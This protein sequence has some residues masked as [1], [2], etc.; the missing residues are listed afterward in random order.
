GGT[1]SFVSE[2][3]LLSP[4]GLKQKI[5]KDRITMMWLTSSLCNIFADEDVEIFKPLRK[6]FTGGEA[7]SPSHIK[8]IADACPELELYN[9]YGP[10]ENTTFTTV[11]KI[12]DNELDGSPIPIGRPISNTRVYIVN[13][14]L[15]VVAPGEWGEICAAGDGLALK[16]I[17]RDD[18][19]CESFVQLPAPV[20]ERVYR[21]G[22]KGR[23]RND[24][25]VEFGGRIDGQVKIRGYRIEMSEIEN[26][27]NLYPGIM[28]SAVLSIDRDKEIHLV[29][30]IKSEDR[31]PDKLL[32]YL[33]KHLPEYMIPEQFEYI[34]MIPFTSNGKMDRK[35]L[36]SIIQNK[37][38]D[39][40]NTANCNSLETK[41]LNIFSDILGEAIDSVDSDFFQHGG[42]SLKALKL[43]NRIRKEICKD[44]DLRIVM[45][46]PTPSKLAKKIM[47]ESATFIAPE[48]KEL[49]TEES[50]FIP[51][52][53]VQERMWFLQEMQ[54]ESTVYTIPFAARIKSEI[55]LQDI[56]KV[57]SLLES[58]HEALRLRMSEKMENTS[59][60]QKLV[61]PGS[62]IVAYHDFS[63]MP[64]AE[65]A[66]R[67]AIYKERE[68]P[69]KFGYDEPLIRLALFRISNNE[70]V[71]FINIHHI[72]F[73][74]VSAS[75]ILREIQLAFQAVKEKRVPA[76][77]ELPLQYTDYLKDIAGR[78]QT[79]EEMKQRWVK[80]MSPLPESLQLPYDMRRPSKQTF[81]G[82]CFNFSLSPEL[83]DGIVN[84]SNEM[85]ITVFTVLLSVVKVF[86]YRHT[87][88]KD[89]VIGV[90]V[91]GRTEPDLEEMV[92]L[93][94]NTLPVR[95]SIEPDMSFY[96][97][98]KGVSDRLLDALSDQ[99]LQL[100]DLINSLK[101]PRNEARNPLFDVLVAMED[102][103]WHIDR[104]AQYL[105][106][107]KYS[108]PGFH[109]RMDLCFYFH[110]DET[111]IN[112]CIEYSTDL[113]YHETIEKMAKRFTHLAQS[114]IKE[115]GKTL[116]SLD[117]LP[118][119]EIQQ[120]IHEFNSTD[121]N[122]DT[123]HSI[124]EMFMK[125]V[126]KY[127]DTVALRE[128]N[129]QVLN[130]RDLD[131]RIDSF[132]SYLYENGVGK[133]THV[134]LCLERSFDLISAI[135]AL[136]RLGAVYVPVPPKIV[137]SRIRSMIEDC[138]NLVILTN[139]QFS[140]L[141]SDLNIKVLKTDDM[142]STK[143]F[144][145]AQINPREIAYLIYTSGSTGR[146]KGVM[147]RHNSVLNRLLWMQS[148]FPLTENDV[149]LQ[150]NNDIIR[151]INMG[152][153]LV[154]MDRGISCTVRTIR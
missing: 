85:H 25:V 92:G 88:Q 32:D 131:H 152:A 101:L 119:S 19:T 36:K 55:E 150:K 38:G 112:V 136:M 60:V 61:H 12:S 66:V 95:C 142:C 31:N 58:R 103:S 82:E 65:A 146:P 133:A 14:H 1:L 99:S 62:L 76:W 125:A 127:P 3:Q 6:L 22:D 41:L 100:E 116:S 96:S 148:R 16:Y 11:H 72:I 134:A 49:Q 15:Q 77:K 79:T 9:G 47:V 80:R 8:K 124:D 108:L 84:L 4:G 122:F 144:K 145:K 153:F 139:D 59:L 42:H 83:S 123:E 26:R 151:C 81:K 40:K 147:I 93:F 64:D 51:L 132:A 74:G 35:A 46:N 138:K 120:V 56:Q 130:Y 34:D 129:G 70:S 117:L 115:P 68:R 109:S 105:K 43:L 18:L 23:W 21:T 5:I 126:S 78:S 30:F 149:I 27:I 137:H 111:G 89:F 7:L 29:A 54:P 33:R 28:G 135:F 104:N 44:I 143:P 13:E 20:N 10:T 90:P 52:N 107:E 102:S 45:E 37:I 97:F 91:A 39:T 141:F 53:S 24:G 48:I 87:S 50:E 94:V 106:M 110:L 75:V 128:C 113:F 67:D 154:V 140:S 63:N 118:L 98:V 121:E 71:L 57:F 69:F 86:I 73:D 2:E 17:G 114:I